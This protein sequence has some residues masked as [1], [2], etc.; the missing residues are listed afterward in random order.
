MTKACFALFF[1]TA[2]VVSLLA[3]SKQE[4]AAVKPAYGFIHNKGQVKDQDHRVNR[5]ALYVLP[6]SN[7]NIVLRKNGFSYDTYVTDAEN[8]SLD[9]ILDL[10]KGRPITMKGHRVDVEFVGANPYPQITHSQESKDKINFYSGS[11]NVIQVHHYGKVLYKDIYPGIDV[12][13]VARPGGDKPV[14][15]NFIVQPTADVDQIQLRYSGANRTMLKSGKIEMTLAN[16]KLTESIPASYWKKSKDAAKVNYRQLGGK[17]NDFMVGFAGAPKKRDE[18]LVID[19]E[20][21]L[22]W[23][24]YIG[25][26]EGLWSAEAK[27]VGID[28][29]GNIFT[30][31]FT[32]DAT[33]IATT[34]S[35]QSTHIVSYGD[36]WLAKFNGAGTRLWGTYYGGELSDK[37]NSLVVGLSGNIYAVGFSNSLS[38][39]LATPGAYKEALAASDSADALLVKFNTDGIRQWGTYFGATKHDEGGG[40]AI[41]QLENV[42]ISGTSGP[43]P[44]YN[45]PGENSDVFLAKFN[46]NGVFQWSTY[47]GGTDNDLSQAVVVDHAQNV[48]LSGTT[49]SSNAIATPGSHQQTFGGNSDGFIAKF[50]TGGSLL[51][52]T[53]YGG[54]LIDEIYGICVDETNN[55]YFGGRTTSSD[56]I[57][58]AGSHQPVL[59]GTVNYFLAKLDPNGQR[60][61]GSY[62]DNFYFAFG[63]CSDINDNIYVAGSTANSGDSDFFISKLNPNGIETWTGHY[64]GPSFDMVTGIVVDNKSN[65]FVSGV[66]TSASGIATPGAHDSNYSGNQAHFLSKFTETICEGDDLTEIQTTAY[67]C[68]IKFKSSDL[69]S[70]C[71]ATYLWDF[72]DNVTST[73]REPIHAYGSSGTYNVSVKIT[74][75]CPNC[76]DEKTLTK[77]VNFN[78]SNAETE[79]IAVQVESDQKP[80]VIDATVST[81][82]DAWPLQYGNATLDNL[83]EFENGSQGVWRNNAVYAYKTERLAS[84][85]INTATDGTYTLNAFNW[86]EAELNAVPGWINANRITQYSSSSAEEENKD[87]LNVYS[88]ALYDPDN[89]LTIAMGSNMRH[90]EMGFTSFEL[91]AQGS[92]NLIFK[93]VPLPASVLYDVYTAKG[94]EIVVKAPLSAFENIQSVDVYAVAHSSVLKQSLAKAIGDDLIVCRQAFS[95]NQEWSFLLLKEKPF[96]DKWL[97]QIKV[98]NAITPTLVGAEDQTV[99]HSGKYSL[100][101]NSETT[102]KQEML[103]LDSAKS[104][105]LSAWVSVNNPFVTTPKLAEQLGIEVILRDKSGT[106]RGQRLLEPSGVVIEGWQQVKNTF[107]CP[108]NELTVELKFK[109]GVTGTAWYD[110]LRIHPSLGNMKS[111]VYDLRDFKLKAILDEENFASYFYYDQEGKL[112]LTKKETID[113]VKTISENVSYLKSSSN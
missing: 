2:G 33:G 42:F 87:V 51:W 39:S 17:G 3:Q 16:G 11:S 78:P 105:M 6:L 82:S 10:E 83:N 32:Y 30:G 19:P 59:E 71:T 72:G 7:N 106:I 84:P 73:E 25:Q 104:Y 77:Q 40:I 96:D 48:V 27:T 95:A 20:P 109:P 98:K 100:K 102:F 28:S 22:V 23:G 110:D 90:A 74:Y 112:H 61:W 91:S 108:D 38:S 66:T 34:G 99:A 55:I 31:G 18:V 69:A 86:G 44:V 54:A 14:E 52:S 89:K 76:Q 46:T 58:T 53:Y 97:G 36:G 12:E 29:A 8:A 68:A 50:S 101:I 65:I 67:S 24:T 88:S 80:N 26:N 60:V 92:G 5:Q 64:G 1:L 56:A 9:S 93:D 79:Q 63:I 21:T 81:F 111:Y 62:W 70:T 47:F 45:L 94:N 41:D 49:K 37:F 107:L 35:H 75:Q 113:G 57:A 103:R 13:F 43:S 15:Y 4:V 85:G